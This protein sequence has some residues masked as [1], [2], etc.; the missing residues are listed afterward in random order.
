MALAP[1]GPADAKAASGVLGS[2]YKSL[3]R[4]MRGT[5]LTDHSHLRQVPFNAFITYISLPWTDIINKMTSPT[6]QTP[7]LL[8]KNRRKN[9]S[10]SS[11]TDAR[12]EQPHATN[13]VSSILRD[14]EKNF[15]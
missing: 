13:V 10:R 7:H 12:T 1:R 6:C 14:V 11:T 5:T 9:P 2:A 4:M 15:N 3:S 8:L